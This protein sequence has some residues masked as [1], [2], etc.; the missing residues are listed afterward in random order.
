MSILLTSPSGMI[1]FGVD[2]NQWLGLM[3]ENPF[4]LQHAMIALTREDVLERSSPPP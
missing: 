1:H 4:V 3:I 2:A